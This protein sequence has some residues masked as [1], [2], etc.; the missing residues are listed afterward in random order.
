MK[1]YNIKKE[2][3]MMKT[4]R[5][6]FFITMAMLM[7]GY[8]TSSKDEGRSVFRE[9]RIESPTSR[10]AGKKEKKEKKE[11]THPK[12]AARKTEEDGIVLA[13][14]EQFKEIAKSNMS[15][16]GIPC[17]IILAQGI[18]E[19]AAG[20][21]TL[22]IKANNHFGIKCHKG[23]QGPSIRHDDDEAQECFRKY[24]HAL[25]S[26]KDH[27]LFLKDRAWYS[28]LFDL[29]K[30]D[31]KAW[32]KGLKAAGYA[33][34][35]RYAKKLIAIIERYRLDALDAEVLSVKPEALPVDAEAAI[36]E[37]IKES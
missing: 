30:D 29:K 3:K 9:A 19:S 13:Y 20:T 33:T 37:E 24:Q 21:G 31:Y 16:F 18:L 12:K 17:S 4:I 28:R 8:S 22:S 27:S 25:E 14:I 15:E 36:E 6:P 35:P 32:A 7:L 5:K 10:T 2:K 23:W 26:Y 34:D 1:L 11:K